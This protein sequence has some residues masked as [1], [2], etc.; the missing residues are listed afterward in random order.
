MSISIFTI[1]KN[2]H[3]FINQWIEYNIDIMKADNIYILIDNIFYEQEPYYIEKSFRNK[4][5][6]IPIT[7]NII[8]LEFSK[9]F[10]SDAINNYKS[11]LMHS[12]LSK[13][14]RKIYCEWIIINAIDQYY[15][16]N[17]KNYKEYLNTIEEDCCQIIVPWYNVYNCN[18]IDIININLFN[19]INNCYT[20]ITNHTTCIARKKYV[21]YLQICSHHF[22]PKDNKQKV[23]IGNKYIIIKKYIHISDL[24][25]FSLN[26]FKS[27]WE[28]DNFDN[29]NNGICFH[30]QLRNLNEILIKDIYSW[31][32]NIPFKTEIKSLNEVFKTDFFIEN[33]ES[34]RYKYIDK[35]NRKINI[36]LLKINL[37][38][39]N[40][41]EYYD[42]IIKYIL[43][44]SNI[45]INI[46][47]LWKQ[48]LSKIC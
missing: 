15:Y 2:E 28:K 33:K 35:T 22:I 29:W 37:N 1:V 5:K 21:D 38:I 12:I 7:M 46:F 14:I 31:T 24:F 39:K 25:N 4:V 48:K 23:F 20:N 42:K 17:G 43:D 32:N 34:H 19:N 13:F 26:N 30:F 47:N 44:K 41:T 11:S 6:L 9:K 18:D 16:F 45:D 40:K 36:K 8:E 27:F 10:I 3:D